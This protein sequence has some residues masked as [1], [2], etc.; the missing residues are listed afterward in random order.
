MSKVKTTKISKT[1]ALELIKENDSKMFTA[2]FI[3]K[4]NSTRVING[5]VDKPIKST[6]LGYISMKEMRTSE[7]RNVNLQTLTNLSIGG[8]KYKI[9]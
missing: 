4:D 8:T 1:K 5:M 2:T 6:N 9:N 7:Y 3:K